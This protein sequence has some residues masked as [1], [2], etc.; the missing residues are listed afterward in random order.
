MPHS[1][2]ISLGYDMFIPIKITLILADISVRLPEGVL[3]DV[4]IRINGCHVP[5]D[6]V[7]LK[8][9]N[10]PKDP[11]I[12]GRPFLATAGAIID[13]KEGRIC[14][15]IGNIP[16]T[17]DMDNLMRRPLIDKQTSNVDDISALA[18]GSFINSCLD[19][20]LE[21]VFTTGE[22]ESFS[23]DSR[24][25]E[26]TRLM[27]A[28]METASVDDIEDDVSEINVDR[29]LLKS[30]DRQPSCSKEWDPEKSPKIELKQLPAGLKYAFLYKD[31]Y[32]VIMNANLTNREFALLLNKLRK[33]RKAIRYSLEDIPGI[34]PDLCMHWI[35]LEDG[36]KLS[37]E[38]QR[39]LNPNLKEVVK[40]EIIKLL[41]VG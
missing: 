27:D 13:V 12:L 7:V 40:K 21:K 2:A 15:N 23:V 41:D 26:Y 38:H 14:L 18:E 16:M 11:L 19:N 8:Y 24:A 9:Q 6:F 20:P 25:E 34:S 36:S 1:V 37:I 28:S 30:V 5:T 39:Q 33:Y 4:P 35:H 22:E 10:E 29:Y 17:F 32:P 3:D 31:S